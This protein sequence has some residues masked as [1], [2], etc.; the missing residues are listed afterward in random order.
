MT[1]K[2][3]LFA[4]MDAAPDAYDAVRSAITEGRIDPR[5]SNT[6]YSWS[7][8]SGSR[9]GTIKAHI[10][11]LKKCRSQELPGAAKLDNYP[12]CPLEKFI[13]KVVLGE[14]PQTS[15]VLKQV[16]EW[17]DEWKGG[18]GE[19]DFDVAEVPQEAEF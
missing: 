6:S 16:L 18:T 2:E 10:A 1:S 12:S 17:L 14:T 3:D 13:T 11:E 19:C 15:P 4:I 7:G 9:N 5:W 8:V